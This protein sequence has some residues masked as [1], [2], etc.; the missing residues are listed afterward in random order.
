MIFRSPY[1]E[2]EIPAGVSLIDFL[3][4]RARL[5]PKKPAFIDAATGVARTFG[6]VVAASERV[7]AGFA[8][9]GLR[10]GDVVAL[11]SPNTFD[12][13]IAYYGVLLAGG[14]VT[15]VNPLSNAAELQR[16]LDDTGATMI[17]TTAELL[18]NVKSANASGRLREVVVFGSA[19]GATPFGELLA[20]RDD[21]PLVTIDSS[22]VCL[23]PM[24]SGTTGLPKAVMLTHDS[25]VANIC[26]MI[27]AETW[28][29]DGVLLSALPLYHLAGLGAFVHIGFAT[30]STTVLM[31]RFDLSHALACIEQYRVTETLW[32]P[33]ILLAM[34]K[35][36][37]VD[38]YDLASLKTVV[39]GAAPVGRE[40]G[41]LFTS[42][43]GC[44]LREVYGLTE[45]SP[46]THMIPRDRIVLGS[47]G[48]LIPNTEARIVDI[49]T[50]DD[51]GPGRQGEL[52]IRGPQVMRGYLSRPDA[53]AITISPDGWLRTGDVCYADDDGF[54]YFVDR[55][56]ELI[57]Y[58]AYQVAPAEL[59][60]VLKG[61]PQ[62]LDAA[63]VGVPDDEAGELP[64]ACVV[65]SGDISAEEIIAYVA[66]RVA[67][68]KKVRLV[69]F[70]D[71]IPKT[72][73]GKILRRSLIERERGLVTA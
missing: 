62:I 25:I 57:K 53:T 35:F 59:E 56:K 7:A 66:E 21:P 55:V 46:A 67:P 8:E 12:W 61:H 13:P 24:S 1:A 19:D 72:A 54:F 33:P 9:R 70:T 39:C 17:V 49:A 50:G 26:Q 10:P 38:D 2:I 52:W 11:Y 3:F 4:D 34:T 47:A 69:E 43:F 42:R 60:D 58:K 51:L 71:Q 73:S 22:S 65:R 68:Y 6:E 40:L 37:H 15:T 14:V 18:D 41:E 30:G 63:V 16:Q 5:R 48:P 44:D 32:V 27:G 36:P 20:S 64:K 23:L 45:A 28:R 29:E 31:D